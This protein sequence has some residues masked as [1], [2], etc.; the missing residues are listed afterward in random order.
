MAKKKGQYTHQS[1]RVRTDI[2]DKIRTHVTN[3]RQ[4][5]AGFAEIAI[6]EKI[7]RDK[8]TGF[9]TLDRWNEMDKK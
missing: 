7:N 5:M 9:P 2:L 8:D 3:T 1:L 6:Q 4:S